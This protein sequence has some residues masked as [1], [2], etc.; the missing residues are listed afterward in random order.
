MARIRSVHP[1]LFSDDEFVRLSL[2][3]QMFYIGILTECD[4][5]GVFEWKPMTL[6][7][8]LRG[9]RDGDVEPLLEELVAGD[10][11]KQFQKDNKLYG[12]V[13]NFRKYQRPKKPT[14]VHPL[15][16]PLRTYVGL[17]D[18]SSPPVPHQF[19][20]EEEKSPQMEEGG[21][22]MEGKEE[23]E[24]RERRALAREILGSSKIILDDWEIRMLTNV[25][26]LPRLS[27]SQIQHFDAI[28]ARYRQDAPSSKFLSV[29]TCTPQWTAWIEYYK[30]NGKP[31][32]FLE[33][34]A[35][36]TVPTEWPPGNF[37]EIP[38]ALARRKA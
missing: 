29:A 9:G 34:Q 24:E 23:G 7:I 28:A 38:T 25:S 5:Q 18:D 12:A 8:R 21:G 17:T 2:G 27:E 30:A 1:G 4:D 36:I 6:K 16:Q 20:T 26:N 22:R 32:K 10:F 11:I 15:P 19:P 13:R 3:A 35:A 14:C 33:K 31:V 37:P